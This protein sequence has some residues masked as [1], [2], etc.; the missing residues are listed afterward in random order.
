MF[1]CTYHIVR[2]P[3][4]IRCSWLLTA[5]SEGNKEMKGKFRNA[6]SSA[7]ATQEYREVGPILMCM[8]SA[9]L[10]PFIFGLSSGV[11]FFLAHKEEEIPFPERT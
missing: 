7:R 3:W 8:Y 6:G 4:R 5:A 2:F 10:R 11:R 1:V 9:V